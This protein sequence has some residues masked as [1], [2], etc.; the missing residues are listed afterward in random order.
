MPAVREVWADGPGL[1]T[2][3]TRHAAVIVAATVTFGAVAYLAEASKDPQYET[4]ALLQFGDVERRTLD[5]TQVAPGDPARQLRNRTGHMRSQEVLE[6][7]SERLEGLSPDSVEDAIE[8]VADP[9]QGDTVAVVAR[10]GGSPERVAAIANAVAEAYQ[11]VAAER[12]RSRLE[13][14][15][16]ELDQTIERQRARL[17]EL[18][19]QVAEAG[20]AS[21]VRLQ[22]RSMVGQLIELTTRRERLATAAA[23]ADAGVTAYD[24]APPG[25]QTAPSPRRMGALGAA[26]GLALASAYAY[27]REGRA[28]AARSAA[29][30][31]SVLGVPLLATLPR[32]LHGRRRRMWRDFVHD[33]TDAY[34]FLGV[35]LDRSLVWLPAASVLITGVRERRGNAVVALNT[36]IA[37]CQDFRRVVLVDADLRRRRLT[38]MWRLEDKV[39][40]ADLGDGSVSMREATVIAGVGRDS[41]WSFIPAGSP[42]PNPFAYLRGPALWR[43]LDQLDTGIPQDHSLRVMLHAPAVLEAADASVVAAFVDGVVLVV[44]KRTQ[45]DEVAWARESLELAGGH[46]LGFVFVTGRRTAKRQASTRDAH[47]QPSRPRRTPV[48]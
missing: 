5:P 10:S 21:G 43:L 3:M 7:A 20:A 4:A 15:I 47:L 42:P 25:E 45:L 32:P 48:P 38:S 1:L 16:T 41:T 33:R 37:L 22:R 2:S 26:V 36:A 40:L 9:D 46:L 34:E 23:L 27:W 39:G 24:P 19:A 30:V 8:I 12:E 28:G 31:H 44:S 14:A 13:A 35:A 18:D 17:A 11:D 6:R 29:E